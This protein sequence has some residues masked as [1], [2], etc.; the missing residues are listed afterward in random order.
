MKP[1]NFCGFDIIQNS[2][3]RLLC[4]RINS[5]G[6]SYNPFIGQD[7]DGN[8]MIF[9]FTKENIKEVKEAMLSAAEI[10]DKFIED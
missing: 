10:L 3:D 1:G 5:M 7:K 8:A 6:E 2:R 9:C 4:I